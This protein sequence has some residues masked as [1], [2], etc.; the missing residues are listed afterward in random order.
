MKD[1]AADGGGDGPERLLETVLDAL[2]V[3]AEGGAD[4]L[5]DA[6][7]PRAR[8]PIG[9][10]DALRRALGNPL[11]APLIAPTRATVDVWDRRAAAARTTVAVDGP[12]GAARYLVSARRGVDGWRLT[13]LRRDDL[14]AG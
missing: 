9:D 6:L 3:G 1:A 14:P 4:A 2:R 13:G 5:F 12:N 11:M 7:T 10:V 8:A